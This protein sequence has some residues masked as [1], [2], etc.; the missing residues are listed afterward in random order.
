MRQTDTRHEHGAQQQQQQ[1]PQQQQQQREQE[2]H[3]RP[4]NAGEAT[5]EPVDSSCATNRGMMWAVLG[6]AG[7][8]AALMYLFDPAEGEYRRGYVARL[9]GK[10]ARGTGHALHASWEGLRDAGTRLGSATA[11]GASSLAHSPL[12]Q[13]LAERTRG[14]REETADRFGYLVHGERRGRHRGGI[15]SGLGQAMAAIGCLA[16]GVGAMCLLDPRDG[17]RRRAMLRDKSLSAFGRMATGLERCCRDAWNRTSGFVHEM[18]AGRREGW[19]DDRVLHERV[20]S[21]IGRC[22]SIASAIDVQVRQGRV[23]LSGLVLASEVD[24]LLKCA[25]GT[26]GVH[27]LINRL[28]VV[29]STKDLHRRMSG[30]GG[31]GGAATG[32]GGTSSGTTAG[33]PLSSSMSAEATTVNSPSFAYPTTPS[34]GTGPIPDR[35]R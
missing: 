7:L 14:F 8:G 20:R 19:V 11:A 31:I 28:E 18:V 32:E 35:P 5:F 24:D 21:A 16:V 17:R 4:W 26:R 1:Q 13:R 9:T 33:S 23:T 10:A 29:T 6:G 22:V 27:E 30:S 3:N 15:E 12:A 34:G 25:W 2:T